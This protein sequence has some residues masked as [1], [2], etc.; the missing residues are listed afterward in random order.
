MD[1]RFV[2]GGGAAAVL[3]AT[4]GG[5]VFTSNPTPALADTTAADGQNVEDIDTSS[6][7]EMTMGDENAPV[8]MIEYASFTCPHCADFHERAWSR[9][10]SD[11]IETGKVRFIYRD[12]YFDKYGLWAA[13]I[14]RCAGPVRFFGIADMFY[15]QQDDWLRGAESEAE[16]ADNL[17]KIGRVAGL[18]NETMEECLNDSDRARTLV[19]WYQQNATEDEI[20]GTPTLIINGEKHSNMTYDDLSEILD[21]QLEG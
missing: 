4:A 3:A 13:M 15:E 14:A 1:R 10:K 20:E 9:L 11:Y 5:Y 19:A 21:A 18:D 6:V 7:V 16:I 12:V 8:T 17:R 2:I